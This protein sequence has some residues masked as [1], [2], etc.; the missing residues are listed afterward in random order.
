MKV[1]LPDHVE[2][3]F[4]LGQFFT[5]M[6]DSTYSRSKERQKD[7]L[8]KIMGKNKNSADKIDLSGMCEEMCDQFIEEALVTTRNVCVSEGTQFCSGT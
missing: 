2:F 7:K 6:H 3:G 4:M 1:F 8:E 5:H